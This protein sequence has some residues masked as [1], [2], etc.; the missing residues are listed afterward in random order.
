MAPPPHCGRKVKSIKTFSNRI[1]NYFF[2]GT[3]LLAAAFV[4]LVAL[5]PEYW[6]F[7][8][9][10]EGFNI[11]SVNNRRLYEALD[12]NQYKILTIPEKSTWVFRPRSS[13]RPHCRTLRSNLA[14]KKESPVDAWQKTRNH[15]LPP[16]E[17]YKLSQGRGDLRICWRRRLRKWMKLRDRFRTILAHLYQ[18][19]TTTG[20]KVGLKI[21]EQINKLFLKRNSQ[22][23]ADQCQVHRLAS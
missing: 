19:R 12:T 11:Y 17:P 20:H 14:Q 8:F 7:A 9:F 5:I 6:Y 4:G 16:D 23:R 21:N 22:F 1:S 15:L 3:G 10:S 13:Y 2:L 18:D